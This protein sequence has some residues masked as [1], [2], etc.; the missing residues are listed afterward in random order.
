M[1]NNYFI[2]YGQQ[3]HYPQHSFMFEGLCWIR[4]QL[5]KIL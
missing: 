3:R 2:N 5:L 1:M 4:F